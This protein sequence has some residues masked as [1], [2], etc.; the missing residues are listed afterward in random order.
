MTFYRVKL[1]T[2][3]ETHKDDKE[4]CLNKEHPLI[5]I[6]WG[7]EQCLDINDYMSKIAPENELRDKNFRAPYRCMCNMTNGDYI[8]TKIDGLNYALGKIQ[9]DLF[10]NTDRPRMGAVRVCEWKN[11]DFDDVPG[12]ITNY[13]VGGGRT[14]VEMNISKSLEE[15]CKWLYC[16]KKGIVKD[17]NLND[18]IHYDDL[19]DLLGL[20]LQSKGYYIYPSTNKLAAKSIEYELIHK[21]TG[22]RACVQCKTGDDIVGDEIFD[23][24][25]DYEIFISTTLDKSY[26]NYSKREDG[27]GVTTVYTD[28]LWEWAFSNKNLLPKRIQN[29]INIINR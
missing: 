7:D 19:E 16:G 17:I 4:Y 24:F 1:F 29:Y 14:L 6:G 3:R 15:Y 26:E 22:K 18:L 11:I 9:G 20:Y 25:K 13:F 2:D 27:K 21:D 8:W 12:K 23:L 28:I 10:I 5:G